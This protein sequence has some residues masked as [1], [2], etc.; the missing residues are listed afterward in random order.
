[1]VA[2][3][4]RHDSGAKTLLNGVTLPAGQSASADLKGALD[5]IF[6]HPNVGPFVC[7]QL[8]QRLVAGNPSPAYVERVAKVFADDGNGVRGDMKAVITAILMDSEARANDTLT[9]DQ[10]A[11]SPAVQSGHLREPA[12]WAVETARGLNAAVANPTAGISADQ[13]GQRPTGCDWRAAVWRA[14]S[15]RLF[16]SELRDTADFATRSGVWFGEHRVDRTAAE[17]GELHH[18]QQHERVDCGFQ[19]DRATGKQ[20][21]RSG[22]AGGL[23]R[24]DLHAQPDAVGYAKRDRG[25]HLEHCRDEPIRARQ[26]G[27]LPSGD[28]APIQS[29]ALIFAASPQHRRNRLPQKG[30]E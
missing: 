16:P 15:V 25:Q 29:D 14:L 26:R 17:H 23:P 19:R 24:H 4:L 9:G 27:G 8:I 22:R 2:T 28:V 12:L 11:T 6:N 30:L 20:G 13:Y 10:L 3:N 18:A 1:M 7:K 5:N 21:L